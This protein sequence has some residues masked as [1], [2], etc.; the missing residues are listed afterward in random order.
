L[1]TLNQLIERNIEVRVFEQNTHK[2][3]KTYKKYRDDI[4]IIWGDL[5]NY[6]D[7]ELAVKGIDIIIH[8]GAIIPPL[9]DEKPELAEAIN[10]GGT[11]NILKAMKAQ[12]K[13]PKLIFTSSIAVYGDR[14]DDPYIRVSDPLNPSEGDNYALTKIIAENLIRESGVPF[15]I[16]RLTYITSVN[17]LN[18]DP[19]MFHMPLETCIEICDVRDVGLALVNAVAVDEVWGQTFNIAGG[20]NC[21]LT[22]KQYLTEMFELFGLGK[23][24][25]SDKAFSKRDFHCGY[26][27]TKKSQELLKYQHHTLEDYYND[28]RRKVGI[29]RYLT[30][31]V[32]GIVKFDLLKRSEFYRKSSFFRRKA[33]PSPNS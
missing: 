17:K 8:L 14:R 20:K 31:I 27:D 11:E 18:L 9:A 21:R 13:V 6:N 12:P 19:L 10:V 2:N 29:K 7:I 30:P 23:K 33:T 25:I 5:R 26:M 28:V 1:S 32:R 3:R 16:F 15:T 24:F 22:Y 4:D